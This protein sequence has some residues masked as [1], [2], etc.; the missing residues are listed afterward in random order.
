MKAKFAANDMSTKLTN[1][2]YAGMGRYQAIVEDDLWLDANVRMIEE[3]GAKTV[4]KSILKQFEDAFSRISVPAAG[5]YVQQAKCDPR[6]AL[7][8]LLTDL[9]QLTQ[10]TTR[11]GENEH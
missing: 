8:R 11:A 9:R 1:P 7:I 3:E 4:I 2:I 10:Q 5:P 6:A